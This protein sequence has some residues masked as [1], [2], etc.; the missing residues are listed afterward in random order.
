ME[1][2]G[3]LEFGHESIGFAV[4]WGEVELADFECNELARQ[5][6]FVLI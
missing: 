6:E 4:T 5:L 3:F 1:Y 2:D